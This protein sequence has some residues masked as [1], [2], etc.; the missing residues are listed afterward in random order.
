M[1]KLRE[2][3]ELFTLKV[4]AKEKKGKRVQGAKCA[5]CT[6]FEFF[7]FVDVMLVDI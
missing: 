3:D 5:R 6:R 1:K 4:S 7:E 2:K